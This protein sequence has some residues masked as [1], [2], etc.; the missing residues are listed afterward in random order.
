MGGSGSKFS[1]LFYPDNPYR[2]ARA[3]ELHDDVK[4]ICHQFAEVKEKRDVLLKSIEPKLNELMKK[5][6]FNTTDELDS[7]LQTIL[8]GD[9]LKEYNRIKKELESK[10]NFTNMVFKLTSIVGA[11]TGVFLGGLVLAGIMTGAA[12]LAALGMIGAVLAVIVVIAIFLSVFEG[13]E[14][15]DKMRKFIRELSQERVRAQ[16]AYAAMNALCSQAYDIKLWLDEPLISGNEEIMTK[17]LSKNFKDKYDQSRRTHVVKYLEDYDRRRGSWINEDPDWQTGP[18][19]ILGSFKE[20]QGSPPMLPTLLKNIMGYTSVAP[21]LMGF[22]ALIPITT[23]NPMV[24]Y[25]LAEHRDSDTNVSTFNDLDEKDDA[26]DPPPKIKFDYTS[27][28]GS[29]TVELTYL[30]SDEASCQGIDSNNNK[31]RFEYESH[32]VPD[33]PTN[34]QVSHYLFSLVNC[35]AGKVFNSCRLN[36]ISQSAG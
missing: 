17:L 25:K 33:N 14:E 19:D 34:I 24:D 7:K 6:G 5:H 15:R 4:F 22:N 1:D 8:N 31:W 20:H 32:V 35:T 26:D 23:Y 16:A 13:K 10:D 30:T 29:G 3:Q 36:M 12:A 21:S 2:R 9:T 18:E 28:D 11:T 27:P